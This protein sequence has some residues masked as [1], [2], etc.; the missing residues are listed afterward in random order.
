MVQDRTKVGAVYCLELII[1]R[2]AGGREERVEVGG[3]E[4]EE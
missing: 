4:R 1:I 3:G 2:V